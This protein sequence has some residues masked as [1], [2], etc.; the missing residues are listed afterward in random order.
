MSSDWIEASREARALVEEAPVVMPSVRKSRYPWAVVL[1]G[2]DGTR[3]QS[4]TLKIAGDSRPKQ[5]CS[6]FGGESLLTQTRARLES[7]FHVDRELLVVTRAHE[8][9]YR[10]ELRNV[11]DS[12]ILPQPLNRGTVV[13]VALALLH[14]LQRDADAV[15]VFVPCDH[16][17]SD[18]EA[19]GR[20]IRSAI[21]GAEQYPDSIVL[22]GAEAHYAEV[23]YGWIELGSAISH[24]QGP[25]LRVNRF[26][27]KPSLPQARALLRRGCLWNTFVTIGN[28]STF[29]DLL[30]S[31]VPNSVLSINK[32]L[33]ENALEAAYRPMP[34]VVSRQVLAPQPH[35]LLVFRDTTSGW[36]DLGSPT[37]VMEV[38]VRN[39][40]QPAWLRDGRQSLP[41]SADFYRHCASR[42]NTRQDPAVAAI[43]SRKE[44]QE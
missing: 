8:A 34:A 15:V 19:F 4:L 42:D 41:P 7:L 13:A 6:I 9:Y 35:R 27:E 33:A 20:A 38:L 40:I 44:P 14:I 32:A 24:E 18:G 11:D 26:W 17:Y 39:I 12:R 1:A 37:R 21:S 28:A 43:T 36:A 2:G 10:D 16:Y 30:C 25:F 29:L 5:F 23:E 31:Q 22:L 3:L